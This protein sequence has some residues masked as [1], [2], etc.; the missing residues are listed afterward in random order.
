MKK[1][2]ALLQFLK[3]HLNIDDYLEAVRLFDVAMQELETSA[4]DAGVKYAG[5]LWK[6]LTGGDDHEK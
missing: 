6:E 3:E 5:E 4:W 2:K 1:D